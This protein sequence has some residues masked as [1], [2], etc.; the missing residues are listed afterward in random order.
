MYYKFEQF[1]K[2]GKERSLLRALETSYTAFYLLH[3]TNQYQLCGSGP[4]SELKHSQLANISNSSKRM[5][6][7]CHL[8]LKDVNENDIGDRKMILLVMK[9]ECVT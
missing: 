2:P 8:N 6:L 4:D 1:L 9:K 3:K 7:N 5:L